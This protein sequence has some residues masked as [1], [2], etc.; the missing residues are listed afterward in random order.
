MKNT[1]KKQGSEV[2]LDHFCLSLAAL[3]AKNKAA[4]GEK[5]AQLVQLLIANESR[6]GGPYFGPKKTLDFPTNLAI[7]YLFTLL[8][9]PL[10][11]VDKFIALR[12][13]G[14]HPAAITRLLKKYDL[15][16][17]SITKKHTPP[18]QHAAIFAAVSH[19]LAQLAQPEKSL[20]LTFLN[21]VQLA[22]TNYEI[23]LLPTFFAHSLTAPH[24]SLPLTQLGLANIYCWVAYSIYDKL[25]DDE[26]SAQFLPVANIAMRKSLQTYSQLFPP[27]HPFQS[28]FQETFTRM[29]HAN[30]WELAHARFERAGES[31][32]ISQLP[33]Y[34]H[35]QILA[36]RSS[37]HILG[38]LAI[39]TLCDV[40]S[41]AFHHF[42]K[43]LRHYLIA[44]QLSDDIHD[45]K[46]DFTAGHAS[47]IITYLLQQLHTSP[48]TYSFASLF[49]AMQANFW[50]SS[51]ENLTAI[52]VRH[53]QYSRRHLLRSGLLQ[54]NTP[55]F[56]LHS[57]L[58]SIAKV[59][60]S[61]YHSSQ[62]FLK[63][64]KSTADDSRPSPQ[65]P[66]P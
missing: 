61:Q 55:L 19:S 2:P 52:I 16:R 12:R 3:Y 66:R 48:G 64:Y 26:P 51:M 54:K 33:H 9:T 45:W 29:D 6:P 27:V 18:P 42:E 14:P 59:S 58:E 7:G 35:Y 50:Q 40:S 10:P 30:A 41:D 56:T 43:G 17:Q 49:E 8:G 37:G 47:S 34:G 32:I 24:A 39:A 15:L 25:L 63:A 4:D 1:N 13:T 11:A 22:D 62:A 21:K 65:L 36:D 38:P 53:L 5:L 60:L 31:I 20:A 28:Y 44:R 46:E 23:A 57:R